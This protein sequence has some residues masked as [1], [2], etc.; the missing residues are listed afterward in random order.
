MAGADASSA[1]LCVLLPDGAVWAYDIRGAPECARLSFGGVAGGAT[2]PASMDWDAGMGQGESTGAAHLQH[3]LSLS[4][5]DSGSGGGSG[6]GEGSATVAAASLRSR[7][8]YRPARYTTLSFG[9]LVYNPARDSLISMVRGARDWSCVLRRIHIGVVADVHCWHEHPAEPHGPARAP[10]V[11]P[12]SL[13]RGRQEA[14]VGVGVRPCSGHV[15]PQHCFGRR[16]RGCRSRHLQVW[17]SAS[18]ALRRGGAGVAAGVP[19]PCC[20][21]VGLGRQAACAGFGAGQR[22][23]ADAHSW[24]RLRGGSSV[25]SAVI[26]LRNWNCVDFARPTAL[27]A[28]TCSS[29]STCMQSHIILSM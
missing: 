12:G 1:A 14:V 13:R 25:A 23:R 20:S 4:G 28:S 15:P 24:L 5:S 10:R 2:G 21:S 16:R 3:S 26:L 8:V 27:V 6:D 7:C 18:R 17:A 29:R 11:R 9:Q 22:R 19:A